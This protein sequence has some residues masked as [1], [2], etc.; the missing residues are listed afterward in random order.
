MSPAILDID[1]RKQVVQWS[2][3]R[4]ANVS[5]ADWLQ[6][7]PVTTGNLFAAMHE[8]RR[9]GTCDLILIDTPGSAGLPSELAMRAA[10]L[11]LV[12]ARPTMLDLPDAF[13]ALRL[14]NRLAKPHAVTLTQTLTMS[15]R[16]NAARALFERDHVRTTPPLRSLVDHQDAMAEGLAVTEYNPSGAAAADVRAL[17]A[18]VRAALRS[19]AVRC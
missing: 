5:E 16:V 8:L 11:T 15:R 14:L 18:W 13:N 9:H 6:V 19:P 17:W 2:K 7:I 10:D 1:P 12:V 3:V 4:R